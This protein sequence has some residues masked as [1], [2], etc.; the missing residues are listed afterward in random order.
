M[1]IALKAASLREE[2]ERE[3]DALIAEIEQV[4]VQVL[5]AVADDSHRSTTAVGLG[6]PGCFGA[7][8]DV[9]MTCQ[10]GEFLVRRGA[11]VVLAEI[12]VYR[13]EDP[14]CVLGSFSGLRVPAPYLRG[15]DNLEA[16]EHLVA[17][18][19]RGAKTVAWRAAYRETVGPDDEVPFPFLLVEFPFPGPPVGSPVFDLEARLVGWTA[20]E[21]PEDDIVLTVLPVDWRRYSREKAHDSDRKAA[22]SAL[23][24]GLL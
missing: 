19:R 14:I 17:V 24:S 11:T 12:N 23:R 5:F 13:R 18:Q 4:T 1:T 22:L 2:V 3:H 9:V 8:A 20:C 16:G 10:T 7:M 6:D 21:P 15:S